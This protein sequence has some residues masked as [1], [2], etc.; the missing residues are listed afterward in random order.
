MRILTQFLIAVMAAGTTIACDGAGT[1]GST[2]TTAGET[3]A[4][5]TPTAGAEAGGGTAT[6]G[7]REAAAIT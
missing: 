2:T 7:T 1:P 4:T 5:A 3:G 6:A